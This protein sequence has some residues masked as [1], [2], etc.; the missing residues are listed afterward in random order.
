MLRWTRHARRRDLT[1]PRLVT[2]LCSRRVAGYGWFF[3]RL[4]VGWQWLFAGWHKL[5]GPT[6]VG[7]VHSSV[8]AGKP[9]HAGDKLLAFWQ[10]A[11]APPPPGSMPQ[12]ALHW[13]AD[14]LRLLIAHHTQAWFAHL[15][16][17]GE[18]LVGVALILGA[19]TAVAAAFG[20]ALNF[21][22]MLAGSAS[23]NPVLF[24]GALSLLLAWRVSGYVGLDRWLL[25]MLGTP[26]QPGWLFHRTRVAYAAPAARH[27]GLHRQGPVRHPQTP[28]YLRRHRHPV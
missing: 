22:Y 19:F 18:F 20:A 27:Q 13:Y 23:L 4:Y 2:A 11:V 9:V 24:L 8:V 21:N 5:T 6:S 1:N 7:W 26:W 17:W 14:F 10:H 15:V 16:A 3:V 28:P 12:V 25:P